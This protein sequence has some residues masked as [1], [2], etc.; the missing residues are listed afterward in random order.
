MALGESGIYGISKAH[1]RELEARLGTNHTLRNVL[2]SITQRIRDQIPGFPLARIAIAIKRAANPI[3]PDD[4]TV[5]RIKR[6]GQLVQAVQLG[7]KLDLQALIREERI[8]LLLLSAAYS[9]GL[10]DV[11]QLNAMLGSSLDSIEWVAGIPEIRLPL[12]IRGQDRRGTSAVVP[13]P[14]P[15]WPC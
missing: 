4:Y 10:L 6:S 5:E 12:S 8:G 15:R 1:V 7:L 13:R 11:A 14:R 3:N 9:G 2:R